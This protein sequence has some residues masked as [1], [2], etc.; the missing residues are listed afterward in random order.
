MIFLVAAG[1]PFN[2]LIGCDILRRN[3]AVIDLCQEKVSLFSEGSTWVANL[4]NSKMVDS[5][6][7]LNHASEVNYLSD[8]SPDNQLVGQDTEDKLW[9]QKIQEIRDFQCHNT[10]EQL[11]ENQLNQLIGIYE[12]Y[13]AVFSDEP[14]KI[15][16]YQCT[17]RLREPVEFN[18]KSYPIAQS[19]KEAVRA[20]IQNMINKDIIESS[21]SPYTSPIVAIQKKSGKVRLP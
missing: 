15:R 6:Q 13:R 7:T 16:N 12:K 3:S 19:L 18:R 20:E 17:I 9:A 8:Y 4:I 21:Q 11:T 2:V 1:L 10:T 14:G 5:R